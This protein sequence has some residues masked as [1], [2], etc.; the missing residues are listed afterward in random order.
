MNI[1][2][3]DHGNTTDKNYMYQYYGDLYREL[4]K[5]ANVYV[6]QG[7]FTSAEQITSSKIDCVVFGLGYFTQTNPRVYGEIKGLKDLDIPVVCMLHKPQTML[8]EKLEFCKINNIDILLDPHITYKEHGEYIGCDSMRFWFTADPSVYYPREVQKI[9]DIGFSGASHGSGKIQGPTR[10]LRDRVHQK[11]LDSSRNMFWNSSKEGSLQYRI[12]SVEEYAT[13]INQSKIWVATTGPVL[14]VSPRYFEVMLSKT[15]LLCNNM[16][17]EYEGLFQDGVNCVIFENDLSDLDEKLDY[18]LS[19][20]DAMNKI[21]DN[22]YKMAIENY[23]WET[24][25]AKL[26]Q[27]IRSYNVISSDS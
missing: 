6:Y 27:K 8:K 3:I 24:M 12:K 4:L 21:I 13:K 5:V 2:Y 25:A 18:Y 26:I 14:D 1:L 7:A 19:N 20:E 16:P 22:A 11:L 23:T 15:L 17:Y 10:D 9:Y